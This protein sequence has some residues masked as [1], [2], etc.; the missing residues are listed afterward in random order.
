MMKI[1]III[2]QVHGHTNI[3]KE[4]QPDNM[5]MLRM[6]EVTINANS[7]QSHVKSSGDHT[8]LQ[9]VPCWLHGWG[10]TEARHLVLME[11]GG[12]GGGK[13]KRIILTFLDAIIASPNTYPC[14]W[15][16]HC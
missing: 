9:L 3:N 7:H 8:W 12:R 13:V 6:N 10:N 2:S 1:I 15:V 4:A 16:S 11:E 5:C 14:Q